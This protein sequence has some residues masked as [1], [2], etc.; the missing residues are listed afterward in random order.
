MSTSIEVKSAIK[1]YGKGENRNFILK[2]LN[3]T[4]KTGQIYAL[5]G[6]SGCGKSTLLQC[7]LGMKS[8]D[9]G[10]ISVLGHSVNTKVNKVSHLIGYMPQHTELCP[11]LTIKETAEYFGN[12]FQMNPGVFKAR[13]KMIHELLELPDD[14]R[15]IEKLSG[16]QMRRVSLAVT[17]IHNPMVLI[18]DEPTVI[19]NY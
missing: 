18:L 11:E 7:L 16:G 14:D 2:G 17:I 10:S 19:K 15:K 8:L 1:S 13:Y 12:V 6:A 5:I 3:M 9:S 4:V